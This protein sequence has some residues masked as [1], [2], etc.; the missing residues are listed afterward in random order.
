VQLLTILIKIMESSKYKAV[1]KSR[2]DVRMLISCT[3]II[4]I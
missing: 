4:N 3:Y 1:A 2:E